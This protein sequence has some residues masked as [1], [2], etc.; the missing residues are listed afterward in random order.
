MT[1][2]Q[3]RLKE[4]GAGLAKVVRAYHYWRPVQNVPYAIWQEDGEENSFDGNNV[5]QE[6]QIHLTVDYFTKTEFDTNVDAIQDYLNS[7]C[8]WRL[9]SVD[10]EDETNLIHYEWEAWLV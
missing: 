4:F 1:S 10:Y 2:F 7:T 6:Q 3:N 9:M 8:G 5:K